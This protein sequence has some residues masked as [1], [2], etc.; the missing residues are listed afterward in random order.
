MGKAC[1]GLNLSA[2]PVKKGYVKNRQN[3]IADLPPEDSKAM[4]LN[5]GFNAR[6]A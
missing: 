2:L 6:S 5:S 3:K 4:M 1:T